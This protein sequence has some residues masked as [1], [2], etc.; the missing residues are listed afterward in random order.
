MFLIHS[1]P[2]FDNQAMNEELNSCCWTGR[3]QRS[4]VQLQGFSKWKK[5]HT[6]E[7]REQNQKPPNNSQAIKIH[8][9]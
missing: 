8:A 7:I 2:F 6:I 3:E 9:Y 1:S 5:I 4:G